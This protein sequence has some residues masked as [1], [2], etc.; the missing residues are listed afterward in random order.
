MQYNA[1]SQS[2][3]VSAPGQES[4]YFIA[5]DRYLGDQRASYNQLLQF[6]LRIGEN[7]PI[8]TQADIILE[9]AGVRVANTI[10]TQN[11]PIPTIQVWTEN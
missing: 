8:P 9:G 5:P 11:N 6:T 3:G 2:I 10:F 7:R 4:V 1:L